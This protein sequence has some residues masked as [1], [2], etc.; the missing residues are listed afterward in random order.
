MLVSNKKSERNI[1][2]V[3]SSVYDISVLNES[4]IAELVIYINAAVGTLVRPG[5]PSKG[6]W[7]S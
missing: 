1:C 6:E 4:G 3:P 5:E 2:R 7:S